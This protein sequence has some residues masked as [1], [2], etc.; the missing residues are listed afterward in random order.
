M[1]RPKPPRRFVRPAPA[2]TRL[3]DPAPST[4][5]PFDLS[6]ADRAA[7]DR[8]SATK[9]GPQAA[10]ALE[11]LERGHKAFAAGDLDTADEWLDRALRNA[12]TDGTAKLS[13]ATLRLTRGD[14]PAAADLFAEVA[15]EW[16]AQAAW[17]GLAAAHARAGDAAHAAEAASVL[18]SRFS[19]DEVSGPVALLARIAA[20]GGLPGWC[21]LSTD[22][23]LLVRVAGSAKA[24]VT[25]DGQRVRGGAGEVP[26]GTVEA[27]VTS[28]GRDLLGSPIAVSR[29]RRIEGWVEP[30]DGGL[31][32]WAWYPA[33]PAREPR[34]L[35]SG[36]GESI[37][38]IADGFDVAGS[39][40]LMQPRS[41]EVPARTL[42]W[43]RGALHVA[44][45][46]G[47]SLTG[48]P[49]NPGREPARAAM[50]AAA[51]ARLWPMRGPP[52]ASALDRALS[53]SPVPVT[54]PAAADVA[55]RPAGDDAGRP[56][57]IV[58]PA[59][60]GAAETRACLDALAETVPG[61]IVHV[62]DDASP[63]ADLRALLD[64]RVE[65]GSIVLHRVARNAGFP[66]AA[67]VGMR[68]AVVADPDADIVL[69]N[70]DTVPTPGWLDVLRRA[71]HAS[72]GIGSATPF[73]NDGSIVS[74]PDAD[75]APMPDD[76]DAIAALCAR[77][78]AGVV[79]DVPTAVGFCMYIRRECL[80]QTGVFREDVFAQG[81][82]EENDWCLR[83][84]HLGWRH[85]VVPG[86]FVAHVGGRSFGTAR[87][88]L[89]A[90]N[91]ENLERLHP[92]WRAAVGQWIAQDPLRDIRRA[93][94]LA[95]LERA[96][97]TLL[98]T[99]D[100]GGGV[101]RFI[102]ARAS[103]LRAE[104]R[105]AVV[106]RPVIDMRPAEQ[107][108]DLERRYT[109]GLCRLDIDA[110]AHGDFPNLL[111]GTDEIENV[112]E[113]LRALGTDAVEV[114]HL[115]GHDHAVMT[116]PDKLGLPYELMVHDH[117]WFCARVT[118]VASG[119]YCGEPNV[120]GCVQCVADHGSRLEEPVEPPELVARSTFDLMGASR[121]LVPTADGAARLRRHFP[122]VVPVVLPHEADP[123]W[124][125]TAYNQAAVRVC[126]VGAIG[127]EKGYDVLLACARDAAQ[128]DLPLSFRI[129]GHTFDDARLL[130]TGRVS[131]T[132]PFKRPEVAGLIRA[133]KAAFGFLSSIWPETWCYALTDLWA[134]G[135]SVA[136]F[137]IGAQA[138][139]VRASGRG[140]LLPLGMPPGA[141]NNAF[142]AR[143]PLADT[144]SVMHTKPTSKI[145]ARTMG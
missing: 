87:A 5:S 91:L 25:Y 16:D 103:V 84:R 71:V 9:P 124:E 142:I 80:A 85:V 120:A 145:D 116:L 101:E 133:Q 74:Y 117:A 17:L 38:V 52:F 22:G 67:N 134:G 110:P 73:S 82:G 113:T 64:E 123:Q 109:P 107:R 45:E 3:P 70:S 127:I 27:R 44:T 77:V 37:M 61:S 111:F 24:V 118:T 102:E 139:R 94:D 112:A 60:R 90:R 6:P 15:L 19:I 29:Q 144:R 96:P 69:L 130:D 129:V 89:I 28:G 65:A 50:V 8:R 115:H 51:T 58:I 106:L 4:A 11:A 81:Y 18:L 93:L 136:A 62:V 10:L 40:A 32:G 30:F 141:L 14:L 99:H 36:S 59:Y 46:D 119:R 72:P 76:P 47:Q 48:S 83:A 56:V 43:S 114:H 100:G 34:L 122:Q 104:G 79:V 26:A 137:D 98:I 55:A 105:R 86:A 68:A 41:F 12:P 39:R 121:V 95:R 2:E 1:R 132:G 49:V 57:T 88:S 143:A 78:A 63:E 126:V 108:D 42:S 138:A 125:P 75:G 33:A 7:A 140:W 53:D 131:I 31:R 92:G 135:L 128:R 23:R 54:I 35:V 97:T 13:L 66:A 20:M 21:A